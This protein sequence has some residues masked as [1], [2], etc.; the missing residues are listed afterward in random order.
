MIAE[1]R[2]DA[3]S[4]VSWYVATSSD[5]APVLYYATLDGQS[6]PDVKQ[7]EGFDVD[8]MKF[9][10]RIDVAFKAADFRAIFKNPGA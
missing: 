7:M 8:G 5:Q 10:A 4:A 1:P 3:S 6:G 9:R 2:L